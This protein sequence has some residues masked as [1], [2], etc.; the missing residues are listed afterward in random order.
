MKKEWLI[1]PIT[2][3]TVVL[4]ITVSNW[5]LSAGIALHGWEITIIDSGGNVGQYSSL[6]IDSEGY[7]CISYYNSS[8]CNLQFAR[9]TGTGWNIEVVD[10]TGDIGWYT[11]LAL[12][13][14]GYPHISYYDFMNGDLKY[15]FSNG[16]SWN[17]QTLDSQGNVGLYTSLALDNLGNPYISY[18]D[19]SQG[20][21]KCYQVNNS[22]IVDSTGDVGNYSSLELNSN[23]Q[24]HISYY[25]AT[26]QALKYTA[27]NGTSWIIETMDL[28]DPVGMLHTCLALDSEDQP[29]ISFKIWND[30]MIVHW[31]GSDWVEVSC[32]WVGSGETWD[33]LVIDSNDSYHI[34]LYFSYSHSLFYSGPLG[35]YLVDGGGDV[36]NF[37]SM[38]LD[39]NNTPMI[40]Y[41]DAID[42]DLRF[43]EWSATA[44]R[45][46]YTP[47][48]MCYDPVGSVNYSYWF[49]AG[50]DDPE[51][52]KVYLWFDWD[53]GNQGPWLGPY[54]PQQV[55][56][57]EHAWAEPGVYGVKVKAKDTFGAESYWTNP[58]N[59]TI[60]S[61]PLTPSA[62]SGPD[63]GY[64]WVQ[65]T[66]QTIADNPS[67]LPL[68]FQVNWGDGYQEDLGWHPPGVPINMSHVWKS[69]GDYAVRVRVWDE[70]AGGTP[71]SPALNVSIQQTLL[72]SVKGGL[73]VHTAI[74][75]QAPI[76][77]S[78][79]TWSIQVVGGIFKRVNKTAKE[80]VSVF[81]PGTKI[82]NLP[83]FFGL[84]RI[85]VQISVSYENESIGW[86]SSATQII[87]W[88]ILP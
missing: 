12:D 41:Y 58:F 65:Y 16:S 73:G 85:S 88:T 6:A 42:G 82:M 25:D 70:Y 55:C 60:L 24:P 40:S 11:S 34:C 10:D 75:N 19:Q 7:P 8:S 9:Y 64:C 62:P 47:F 46:P 27:W 13:G 37:A 81:D 66:Y 18:Y 45:P 72:V 17:V 77:L 56:D 49:Y 48:L 20:N 4:F 52:D 84:G 44:N 31:N 57:V 38:V 53:D 74:T 50:A 86:T 14:L 63:T 26:N 30:V 23:Y 3:V 76:A 15:A 67:G 36:G 39:A 22:V 1:K 61:P 87:F 43:A 78:N 51:H 33:S 21:L 29:Y 5:G 80:V 71:W 54:K 83:P 35:D 2:L 28:P 69:P 68:Y 32:W 79:I 59:I